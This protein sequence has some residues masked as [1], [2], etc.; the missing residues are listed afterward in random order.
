M[1]FFILERM[2]SSDSE[3][4]SDARLCPRGQKRA[5]EDAPEGKDSAPDSFL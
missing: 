4:L 3:Q 5:E 1:F 2:K